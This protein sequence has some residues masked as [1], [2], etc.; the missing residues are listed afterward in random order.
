MTSSGPAVKSKKNSFKFVLLE[1]SDVRYFPTGNL[2]SGN[3]TRVFSLVATSQ[4]YPIRSAWPLLQTA[5]PQRANLTFG[6]LSLGKLH[7]W[8]VATWEI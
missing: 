6:K 4:A 7:I 8:E 5:A 2:P 1:I 3:F